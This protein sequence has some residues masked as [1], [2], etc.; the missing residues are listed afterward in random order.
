M[1]WTSPTM[2]PIHNGDVISSM[3]TFARVVKG[4]ERPPL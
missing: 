2:N 1:P 3:T 4:L